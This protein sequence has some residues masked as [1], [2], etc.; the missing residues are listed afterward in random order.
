MTRMRFAGAA[1]AVCAVLT[2]AVTAS[3]VG[4]QSG[5]MD[6]AHLPTTTDL[7]LVLGVRGQPTALSAPQYRT[8]GCDEPGD[9]LTAAVEWGDGTTSAAT[10]QG[11]AGDERRFSVGGSHRYARVSKYDIVIRIR[12][13]RTGVERRDEHYQAVIGE[14]FGVRARFAGARGAGTDAVIT[15]DSKPFEPVELRFPRRS[16]PPLRRVDVRSLS[17]VRASLPAAAHGR[18]VGRLKL[19]GA[20]SGNLTLLAPQ[21]P[22]GSR[23]T[24][25][26]HGA[27]R[28]DLRLHRRTLLE[29]GNLPAGTSRADIHF[30][31]AGRRILSLAR[32]CRTT[33][34]LRVHAERAGARAAGVTVTLRC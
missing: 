8:P 19:R 22:L 5:G 17:G 29:I 7:R 31:G 33:G 2:A 18:V 9:E 24:L 28:V 3:S 32:G 16:G 6:C 13:H 21:R 14:P 10:I 12:N 1:V 25:L 27:L 30:F 15:A 34:R 26:R 23:V 4:Q 11:V 20:T